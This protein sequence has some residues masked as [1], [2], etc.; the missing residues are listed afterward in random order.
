M[1]WNI[2]CFP[3]YWRGGPTTNQ[4]IYIIRQ[5]PWTQSWPNWMGSRPASKSSIKRSW[6][7]WLGK[8]QN[9][10]VS[11]MG[12]MVPF[13]R[14]KGEKCWY[15]EKSSICIWLMM[16]NLWLMMVNGWQWMGYWMAFHQ[17]GRLDGY[18]M[19]NSILKWMMT[20][21]VPQDLKPPSDYQLVFA[22]LQGIIGHELVMCPYYF[23]LSICWMGRH[24]Y[25]KLSRL[26]IGMGSTFTS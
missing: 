22:L 5:G 13:K 15:P 17:W 19:E 24:V 9:G 7:R 6:I 12:K 2:F 14:L 18:F 26:R 25:P 21:R 16:V 20:R 23:H 4:Y 11:P 1:V 10:A 3:I 8:Q